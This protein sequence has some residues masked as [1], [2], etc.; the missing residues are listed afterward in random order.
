MKCRYCKK[1]LSLEFLDLG[2]TP[3]ANELQKSKIKS[4]K[5]KKYHLKV[6]VCT[7]C[8]LY[9]T[10]MNIDEKKI[11]NS[12]YTYFSSYSKLWLKHASLYVNKIIKKFSI[13]KNDFVIEIASNDGYLL[14]NF[15]KNKIPSLG[16]EPSKNTAD[17]AIKKNRVKTLPIFFNHKSSE[18][19]KRNFSKPKLIIANNV[20]AHVPNINDFVKGLKNL[21]RYD[22]IIN[23]EFPHLYN[24]IKFKQFDTI[25]HE[26]Y[27]YL[28]IIFLKKIFN[29]HNLKI[30]NIEK[31][32]THGGSLRIYVCHAGYKK[33]K[34]KKII[35]Q[36]LNN[37]I[38]Y[39]IKNTKIIKKLKQ[40]FDFKKLKIK[41]FFHKCKEQNKIV[42]GYSAPAKA[43]TL[44]NVLNINR[45]NIKK[46]F[47]NS[48]IKQNKYLPGT[49]IKILNPKY[50][51]NFKMDFIVVFAWNIFSEIKKIMKKNKVKCKL[52]RFIP[53]IKI[54]SV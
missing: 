32:S 33:F 30:F 16:I 1:K 46:I 18:L 12:K 20:L 39:G 25:Y 40:E 22:G 13:N 24:L 4:I 21:L 5:Q 48:H 3:I 36:T 38:R 7:C 10:S 50:I 44:C 6:M 23:I 26:H 27:S 11:F 37:E 52:V 51:L 49:D 14:K 8:W 43:T 19:I 15:I 42:V 34:T 9:Q 28:S 41:S 45:N 29:D 53:N 31:I 54:E 2:K 47:D 35:K 17:V